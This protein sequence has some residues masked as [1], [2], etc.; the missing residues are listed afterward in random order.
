MKIKYLLL[1][2]LLTFIII[3]I[4]SLIMI[5][6]NK[7]E[8]IYVKTIESYT[9]NMTKLRNKIDELEDSECK[10]SLNRMVTRINETNFKEDVTIKKYYEAY[11][12]DDKTF[13]SLYDDIVTTCELKDV[14]YIYVDVLRQS[15]FPNSI[16]E[17]YLLSHELVLKDY[18]SRES[19]NKESYK[20][21]TYVTKTLELSILNDLI[22]EVNNEE[23]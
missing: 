7:R 10:N 15:V 1:G 18:S 2:S 11:F 6:F 3:F 13:L 12:K 19:I 4:S 20:T 9:T 16:K 17:K 23:N 14:D 5:P 8:M 22:K 21:G